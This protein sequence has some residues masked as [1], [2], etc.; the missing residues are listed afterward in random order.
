M[1][2]SPEPPAGSTGSSSILHDARPRRGAT[3]LAVAASAAVLLAGC[4]SDSDSNSG[5]ST[6]TQPAATAKSAA[7]AAEGGKVTVDATEYAFDPIAITAKSGKLSITLDNKGKVP[8]ELV[9]LKTD[10][11]P[12]ALEVSGG[13]VSEDTSVGE[14]SEIDGGATKTEKIDLKPGKYVFVCNIPGHYADGM[15]GALTVQ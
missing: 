5:S 10:D 12:D 2:G 13:R 9:V 8:H 14:V 1:H 7:V 4:G 11:A 3:L 15:R 6:A